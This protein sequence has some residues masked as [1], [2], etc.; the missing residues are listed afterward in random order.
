LF[1]ELGKRA[2]QRATRP[3]ENWAIKRIVNLQ[4]ETAPVAYFCFD[5]LAEIADTEHYSAKPLRMQKPQLM[6]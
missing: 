3:E 2:L 6:D 5:H 1:T 4:R